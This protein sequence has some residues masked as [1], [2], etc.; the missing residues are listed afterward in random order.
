MNRGCGPGLEELPGG[1]EIW[2]ASPAVRFLI[3]WEAKVLVERWR[4]EYNQV[5]PHSALGY[6]G[7]APETREPLPPGSAGIRLPAMALR[8]PALGW[9]QVT[10]V[11]E[12]LKMDAVEAREILMH[13]VDSGAAARMVL[14]DTFCLTKSPCGVLFK[15]LNGG[16]RYSNEEPDPQAGIAPGIS[17]GGQARERR[18]AVLESSR[19]RCLRGHL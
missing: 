18:D 1:T 7:P 19:G 6:R 3:F 9:D 4:R 15:V 11:Q 17:S 10:E 14:F 12:Q 13:L 2:A 16:R 8:L 5:R